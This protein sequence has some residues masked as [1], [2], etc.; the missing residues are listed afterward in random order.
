LSVEGARLTMS[1]GKDGNLDDLTKVIWRKQLALAAEVE[2]LIK[3]TQVKYRLFGKSFIPEEPYIMKQCS[4]CDRPAVFEYYIY[5]EQF[6]EDM[7]SAVCEEEVV[8]VVELR[9]EVHASAGRKNGALPKV[10]FLM[11]VNADNKPVVCHGFSRLAAVDSVSVPEEILEEAVRE[12]EFYFAVTPLIKTWCELTNLRRMRKSIVPVTHDKALVAEE[13]VRV[14]KRGGKRVKPLQEGYCYLKAVPK[15]LRYE[16]EQTLGYKPHISAVSEF[17]LLH[18]IVPR[19]LKVV[20]VGSGAHMV[21]RLGWPSSLQWMLL[22]KVPSWRRLGA[23]TWDED[24]EECLWQCTSYIDCDAIIEDAVEEQKLADYLLNLGPNSCDTAVDAEENPCTEKVEKPVFVKGSGDCW[25]KI[26]G[27][28]KGDQFEMTA[29]DLIDK[30][31]ELEFNYGD[32][33]VCIEWS[34]QDDGDL[35]VE[36]AYGHSRYGCSCDKK[37]NQV[38]QNEF[39][40][41]LK[42]HKT[43]L[44]GAPAVSAFEKALRS[45]ATPDVRSAVERLT[46][47]PLRDGFESIQKLCPYKIP[48]KNQHKMEE[49]CIPWSSSFIEDH[50]HPIHAAIRRWCYLVEL[51]K[52]IKTDCTFLGMKPAHFDM[53]VRAVNNLHGEGRFRMVLINTITDLKDVARYSGS[54]TV[55]ETVW[56]L[57]KIDTPML[58]CDESGHYLSP[59]WMVL[60]KYRN[61]GLQCIG[62]SNI[63]PLQS[64]QF[65]Q[66]PEPEYVNWRI[67]ED[68]VSKQKILI[69]IPE[70]DEGGKYEQPFDPTMTLASKIEDSDGQVIWNGGVVAS[71][72]NLRLQMFYGYNIAVPVTIVESQYHFINLP[73][74]FRRQPETAP[75]RVDHFVGLLKYAAILPKA[76]DDKAIWGKLRT[77]VAD[78][79]MHVDHG[80]LSWLVKVVWECVKINATTDLASKSYQGL[81]DELRYKTIGLLKSWID[82]KVKLKYAKRNAA[83]IAHDDPV[84]IWPTLRVIVQGSDLGAGY[85][86]NWRLASDPPPRFWDRF[87]LWIQ[88]VLSKGRK[89]TG[90]EKRVLFD[91]NGNVKFPMLSN[92]LLNQQVHGV[93]SIKASQALA[94]KRAFERVEED[95]EPPPVPIRQ[96]PLMKPMP[97]RKL[98]P[99][100]PELVP[101]PYGPDE[102][103]RD[104]QE[105]LKMHTGLS[106]DEDDDELEYMTDPGSDGSVETVVQLDPVKG[107]YEMELDHRHCPECLSFEEAI[108]I[109]M[110]ENRDR[111]DEYCLQ[112]HNLDENAQ[113]ITLLEPRRTLMERT[114]FTN[115]APQILLPAEPPVKAQAWARKED[116]M[117]SDD[118][119]D[120]Q[121][122]ALRAESE[123]I[124]GEQPYYLRKLAE[125]REQESYEQARKEW[126]SLQKA[127]PNGIYNLQ[128]ATGEALWNAL[129]P[130]S[131]SKRYAKVPYW[132]VI[133]YPILEYP[134]NDC[135]LRA[136]SIMIKKS[137]AEIYYKMSRAWPAD[138][139]KAPLDLPLKLLNP[140]AFSYGLKIQVRN[141]D[142]TLLES[143]GVKDSQCIVTLI[144]EKGHVEPGEVSLPMVID[145]VKM[146]PG[147]LPD[148]NQLIKTV[149]QLP[150]IHWFDWVPETKR[151]ADLARAMMERTTGLLGEPI[152]EDTLK[153]WENSADLA[154][155]VDKKFA[156]IMGEPGCRKSSAL[157]KI[158]AQKKFQKVGNF[159]VILPTSVLAGDWRDKLDATRKDRNG[160]GMPGEMVSTFEVA[161]ARGRASRLVVTDE[162]K[163]QKGYHA[164]YH[165]ANPHVTHQIFLCD[166]WQTSWHEPNSNCALNDPDIPGEAELYKKYA[167]FY[168]I[169]TWRLSSYNA[170]FWQ[171]PT[172][173]GGM[174]GFFFTDIY[175]SDHTA[176]RSH[177]PKLN[178][179]TIQKLWNTRYEIYP[180]H[181]DTIHADELRGSSNVT[182]AGSQGLT[183]PLAIIKIDD[184]VLNGT[185]PR[186]LYTS[187]TRSQ[188]ILFVYTASMT[189]A[190]LNKEYAHPVLKHLKYYRDRYKPGEMHPIE[191]EHTCNIYQMTQGSLSRDGLEIYLSGHPD[192]MKNWDF[193][194]QFH[195][196]SQLTRYIEP[197]QKRAGARLT[198]D[199]PAYL[200]AYDFWPY[201]DETEE[202]I[203]EEPLFP[204]MRLYE[205]KLPTYLPVE[206]RRGFIENYKQH[207]RERYDWELSMRGEY[208]DQ[209]P[210]GYQRRKDAVEVMKRLAALQGGSRKSNWREVERM[211]RKKHPSENPTLYTT[212]L[213]NEGLDQKARDHVSFLAA[214][215]QRIRFSTV[216]ANLMQMQDQSAF[217]MLCWTKFKEYM[218][219]NTPIPW[220]QYQFDLANQAFQVRRGERSQALK[221]QSLNRTDPNFGMMLTAKTQWKLKDRLAG[222][223]KPLQPVMIHSDSYLFEFGP[224]GVYLLEMLMAN[225]PDY[226]YFHAKKTPED[227][228]DWCQRSFANDNVF[229]MNDQ[230]GQDQSVQGWAVVF[231]S[232]LLN[233]F[234]FPNDFIERFKK[235][236]TTKELNGK[237][238]GI[239][240]DSGEVWT[241]LINSTSSSARECAM[242]NLRPGHPMAG[243]GDDIMRRPAGGVTEEYRSVEHLDPSIDKRYVSERGDFCSF[244]LKNHR[245]FKDPIILLKRF[246]GKVA[247]GKAEEAVLGYSLLWSFNYNQGDSLVECLD[248]EELTAQQL[249]NRQMFNLKKYGIR[250]KPDWSILKLDGEPQSELALD[251][252]TDKKLEKVVETVE[253]NAMNDVHME[254]FNSYQGAVMA[255]VA[256]DY[257]GAYFDE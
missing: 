250:T 210:D 246:M 189:G 91:D 93:D 257:L 163:F 162:N 179:Q 182:Y 81:A 253:A 237:V 53:V 20:F 165:I 161:L 45:I 14:K 51:P 63:F 223:A 27:F 95:H 255:S 220:D 98:P 70:E 62:M 119:G 99:L 228:Q 166:P 8:K 67:T 30:M 154:Q 204:G 18:S 11:S 52:Y 104:I 175:P 109:G 147:K 214:F 188:Y 191:P 47:A 15:K 36:R 112:R 145:N 10:Q 213:T 184:R 49:L 88:I 28:F 185:D 252:F 221:K 56:D 83:L 211:L 236:K 5:E 61:P 128:Q 206:D 256:S 102:D 60:M 124:A 196:V 203:P 207:Q 13:K 65:A 26:P 90:Y 174:G 107:K 137:R 195:D 178:E 218:G 6:I 216:E 32:N 72:G 86:V 205:P 106:D 201:I 17:Y 173:K 231:F 117:K 168:L 148:Q 232:E 193:V 115:T 24:L 25:K 71:K 197:D 233:H 57:P 79:K 54:G 230:K 243:G 37:D 29:E 181:V 22:S 94:Y 180:A 229:E 242:F 129:Y 116:E 150:T 234:S 34:E 44:V 58:Y 186:M 241:Y 235:D 254:G 16:A 138:E 123:R 136:M 35:H 73:R 82:S 251:M 66:S 244:I 126:E 135:V 156:V 77:Y 208:S 118:L 46:Q 76:D 122:R 153:G 249:L 84:Q 33:F 55:S 144:L 155:D 21:R 31:A 38:T 9:C 152:N 167:K 146:I 140:V 169:G 224:S 121:A 1:S 4:L 40:E 183:F 43:K 141:K 127:R 217:G 158:F 200:E 157:Q 103:L 149:S 177:F 105:M 172:F 176:L 64:L 125:K 212:E 114:Y 159:T 85:G 110:P 222:P 170:N 75:V 247:M 97:K 239:M 2:V 238:L 227:L 134:E 41:V 19:N 87:N 7:C 133:E 226:W 100:L 194:K 48:E 101:L 248:E 151:A 245:L 92:S 89:L 160:R 132:K 187:M 50:P 240:T 69:Y 202:F 142:G 215:Q 113:N 139:P 120:L 59:H 198:R 68:A 219:W 42:S 164:L 78:K 192:D 171:M 130:I 23:V 143:I 96:L 111:Y 209:L 80:S 12:S 225:K 74:V 190:N 3:A 131:S 39:I 199:D 108:Q